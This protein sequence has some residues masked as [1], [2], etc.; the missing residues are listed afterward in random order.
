MIRSRKASIAAAL[1]ALAWAAQPA[2]AAP[3]PQDKEE[4]RLAKL[5][6]KIPCACREMGSEGRM[7]S[8]SSVIG[9]GMVNV[10]VA[11]CVMQYFTN[12]TGELAGL[13]YCYDFEVLH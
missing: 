6:R 11:T 7:G 2:G 5:T 8:V 4:K 13:S 10:V 9:F 3:T 12:G 1:L